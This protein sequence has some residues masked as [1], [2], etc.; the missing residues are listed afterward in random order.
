MK[1]STEKRDLIGVEMKRRQKADEMSGR[2]RLRLWA[3]GLVNGCGRLLEQIQAQ[4][5][6]WIKSIEL[7]AHRSRRR[8]GRR[9]FNSPLIRLNWN[10]LQWA[11]RQ[12]FLSTG[13]RLALF[14]FD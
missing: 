10:G 6:Y 5:Q 2:L 9:L 14:A 1:D 8:Q 13:P 3:T 11:S 4:Y 12:F 7:A